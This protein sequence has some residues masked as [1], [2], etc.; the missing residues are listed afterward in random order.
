MDSYVIQA[1]MKYA[2][3]IDVV[4]SDTRV[5]PH[6]AAPFILEDEYLL[7]GQVDGS[8]GSTTTTN[9]TCSTALT[10]SV[11]SPPSTWRSP[12]MRPSAGSTG[13]SLQRHLS[14]IAI[15]E[16]VRHV[17]RPIVAGRDSTERRNHRRVTTVGG[18]PDGYAQYL[19]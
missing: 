9:K 8:S 3:P 10:L 6:D 16:F 7:A 12:T 19:E 4:E 13:T 14:S 15:I 1:L 17:L 18:R 2:D 11:P 5:Q